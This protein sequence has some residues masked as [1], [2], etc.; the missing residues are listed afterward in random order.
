MKILVSSKV[1]IV[2]KLLKQG[3]YLKL[4]EC[5]CA[6]WWRSS[7]FPIIFRIVFNHS[8]ITFY[9]IHF[10]T[11]L[12]LLCSHLA[13]I[14]LEKVSFVLYQSTDLWWIVSRWLL[15]FETVTSQ[16]F[17]IGPCSWFCSRL[18]EILEIDFLTLVN[19]G[20]TTYRMDMKISIISL[21]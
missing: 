18:L 10:I 15:K 16:M 2:K 17:L 1:Q 5:K 6:K 8:N 9:R 4:M 14:L 20:C 7:L 12:S 3:V 13:L 11:D 21:R 19:Y